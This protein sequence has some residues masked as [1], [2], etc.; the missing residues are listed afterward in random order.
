MEGDE[1]VTDAAPFRILVTGSRDWTDERAIAAALLEVRD[2]AVTAGP[3]RI[4]VVD[5]ACPTGVDEIAHRWARLW[6]WLTERHPADWNRYGKAAGFRRNAE[7]VAVGADTCLAFIRPCTKPGCPD[8]AN[9]P[10]GSHGAT[11]C[12]DRAEGAGIPT[13]RFLEGQRA[14]TR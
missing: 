2:R 14:G 8:H 11:D 3:Q 4:L 12:A 1:P 10:H 7:M 13:A 5:G 9:G 6:G